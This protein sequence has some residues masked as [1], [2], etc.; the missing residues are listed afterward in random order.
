MLKA[1]VA[2]TKDRRDTR[3]LMMVKSGIFMFQDSENL[4]EE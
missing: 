2:L 3:S 4:K 1:P